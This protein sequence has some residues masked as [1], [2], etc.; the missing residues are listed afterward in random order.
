MKIKGSF[1]WPFSPRGDLRNGALS[2]CLNN[3]DNALENLQETMATLVVLIKI[4]FLL[5]PLLSPL[6]LYEK[7]NLIR[8]SDIAK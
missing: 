6:C 7:N 2:A 3:G 1:N 4:S 8:I 5:L